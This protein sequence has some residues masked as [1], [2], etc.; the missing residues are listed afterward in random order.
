[1][2]AGHVR[3]VPSGDRAVTVV[4]G[5]SIEE[6]TNGRV[7]AMAR[8][9][10]E[11]PIP[12]VSEWIPAYCSLLVLYDPAVA[13]FTGLVEELS[14]REGQGTGK[15]A[16]EGGSGRGQRRC[17]WQIPVCYGAR[18][19]PDLADMERL[20][21]LGRDEIISLHS[22]VDY[23]IYMMG[24]LPGFVYLGGL[25][26]QLVAPRLP[27]PRLCIEPGSVGI[28]GSQTGV[29]PLAS[30]GGWRLLG[31]TPVDFYNPLREKPILCSA[32]EYIRFVPVSLEDY[33]DIRR[34][35]SD[36]QYEPKQ[37]I[38]S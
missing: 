14:R 30:P 20:S 18:F 4:F 16:G 38:V 5:E 12:G 1:M 11:A 13:G 19:G 29:Y 37:L 3:Y 34:A 36:G 17:I 6:G 27:S 26:Q 7:H 22:S 23:H 15:G 8:S 9:L 10:R 35:V 21:G 2:E 33:Y 25:P 31:A 32:G 24:F 28:G